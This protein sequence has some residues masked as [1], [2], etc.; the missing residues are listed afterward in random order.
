MDSKWRMMTLDKPQTWTSILTKIYQ[1][2]QIT[3]ISLKY[4]KL[5]PVESGV[6]INQT[7]NKAADSKNMWEK[8][9]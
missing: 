3:S 6:L 2:K 7:K 1:N 8:N 4:I 5:K 9:I